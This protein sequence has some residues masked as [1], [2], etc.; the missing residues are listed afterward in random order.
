VTQRANGLSYTPS[1]GAA[2]SVSA[3]IGVRVQ[4]STVLRVALAVHG[5][6]PTSLIADQVE[7]RPYTSSAGQGD[8]GGSPERIA[9]ALDGSR[10]P[11]YV[12][13]DVGVRHDWRLRL[14]GRE[15]EVTT[16]AGLTNL[17]N[18]GNALGILAAPAGSSA[19]LL[20]PRRSA[21]FGLEW[22]Y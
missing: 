20:L 18:R 9:G 16:S 3:A 14:F 10:L 2:Q 6:A 13:F 5:G 8:L 15:S 4:P 11:T 22:K 17:F 19:L 7:W 1:Y 21:T 12:R